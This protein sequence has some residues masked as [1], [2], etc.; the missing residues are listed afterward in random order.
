[1]KHLSDAEETFG[2]IPKEHCFDAVAIAC[3]SNI[4][5]DG[6]LS[7]GFTNGFRK[8]DKVMYLGKEYFIKGGMSAGYTILISRL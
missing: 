2:F 8:F 4:T 6:L 1:M 7:I 5:K 3:L